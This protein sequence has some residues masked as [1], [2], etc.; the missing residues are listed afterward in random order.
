MRF[1][2][3]LSFRFSALLSVLINI[4][5][6]TFLTL[7][8]GSKNRRSSVCLLSFCLSAFSVSFILTNFTNMFGNQADLE[9]SYYLT[10]S[11][12]CNGF[13]WAQVEL[14][15]F[16]KLSSPIFVRLTTLTLRKRSRLHWLPIVLRYFAR[17]K[18]MK[19]SD[20]VIQTRPVCYSCSALSLHDN[21]LLPL[22]NVSNPPLTT[23]MAF[24]NHGQIN[25]DNASHE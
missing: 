20:F 22:I 15:C 11:V 4:S 16:R 17:R 25:A 21:L 18:M 8:S 6:V 1:L 24:S 9:G 14:N 5:F 2:K 12:S 7:F 10:W 19:S 23:W 13:S 3:T